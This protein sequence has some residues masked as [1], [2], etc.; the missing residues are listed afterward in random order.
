MNKNYKERLQL[1][2]DENLAYEIL[3]QLQNELNLNDTRKDS[4]LYDTVNNAESSIKTV[5]LK[6]E[7]NSD[8]KYS[9]AFKLFLEKFI[10]NNQQI[11]NGI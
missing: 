8:A 9:L 6:N 4:D 7:E 5:S 2:I 10:E 1:H 3:S 11:F